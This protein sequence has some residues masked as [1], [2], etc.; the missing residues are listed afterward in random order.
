MTPGCGPS[1]PC[2]IPRRFGERYVVFSTGERAKLSFIPHGIGEF[3][4]RWIGG[5]AL[6]LAGVYLVLRTVKKLG[7]YHRIPVMR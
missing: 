4:M 1:C 2:R 7:D 6:C 5:A 3:R